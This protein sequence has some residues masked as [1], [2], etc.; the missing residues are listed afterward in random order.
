MLTFKSNGIAFR[1][2]VGRVAQA[3]SG[4]VRSA[5]NATA[6]DVSQKDLPAAMRRAF[7]APV[8]FT[9][10]AFLYRKAV[11]VAG[12]WMARVDYRYAGGHL[13]RHYL[14]VQVYG[15]KRPP[16][17]IEKLVSAKVKLP[18]FP[19]ALYPTA[20]VPM[21]RNGN[22][23]R[24]FWNRMLADLQA[25]SEVG[26]AANRTKRSG[27]RNKAYAKE[28]FF[29]GAPGVNRLPFGVWGRKGRDIYPVML[30]AE[31][32]SY[33]KRLPLWRIQERAIRHRFPLYLARAQQRAMQR[34]VR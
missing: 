33:Q 23:R 2:Q 31:H 19:R 13:K 25:F 18:G 21:D 9:L 6:F 5:V 7:K 29:I 15:G 16:K 26:F 30:G 28:R 3:Q 4:A 34:A 1:K 27:R 10:K 32:V 17:A 8:R 14:E 22:V 11:K 12:G 20:A 24:S